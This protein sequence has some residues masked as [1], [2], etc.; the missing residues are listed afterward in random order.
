MS[1]V[2]TVA[3][4]YEAFGSGDIPAIIERLH[5]DVDWD[6]GHQ[7]DSV[8]WIQHRR[9]REGVLAFF[10]SLAGM[11]FHR[12][13]VVD[14]LASETRVAAVIQIDI[15]WKPTGRRATDLEL[16][17]WQFDDAGRAVSFRHVLDTHA[18]MKLAGAA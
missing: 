2:E 1:N 16:H 8:P 3:K 17:L 18:H 15:T 6:Y 12:F 14:L 7:V 5:P 11:E 9:G 10:Q 4:I 13:E